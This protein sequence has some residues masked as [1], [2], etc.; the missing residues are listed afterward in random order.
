MTGMALTTP[1]REPHRALR[2]L[3]AALAMAATLA[4]CNSQPVRDRDRDQ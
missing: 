3:G 4:G 1:S 2:R